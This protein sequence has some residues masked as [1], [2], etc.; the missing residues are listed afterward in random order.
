VSS[1]TP[2]VDFIRGIHNLR[3]R[4]RGSAVTIGNFDGLHLGH[5]A[6]IAQTVAL[7]GQ[8]GSV[9]TAV[10]FEP[11]PREFFAPE[12]APPRVQSLRE[13]LLDLERYGIRRVLCLH[14]DARQAAQPA[15]EF[16][17]CV[18]GEGLGATAVVVGA[19]FRFG[20]RRQGDLEMIRQRLPEL[21]TEVVSAVRV[22]DLRV[23][24]TALREALGVPDL[25]RAARLLGRPY[26]MC[27]RVR[28]GLKLGTSQLGMPTANLPLRRRVALADGV[29]A[30][31][32][33]IDG[34]A[35]ARDGVASL[36]VRPTLGS[37]G[38]RVL[39]TH[40]FDD[41]GNLYG[42]PLD[43]QFTHFLRPQARFDSLEALREQMHADAAAARELL[44]GVQTAL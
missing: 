6:L 23:S 12:Q 34:D 25:A 13:K 43:I 22:D 27:G 7:A 11:M 9:P 28:H 37:D 36:G 41:P 29:Y 8:H 5:Q 42:R 32:V 31:R 14:F 33:R 44:A 4:H 3:P 16:V 24:S 21:V 17:D 1:V 30:V 19:D 40:L 18:L 15:S 2:Q 35:D 20:A 26:R 39:E 38:A 10:I